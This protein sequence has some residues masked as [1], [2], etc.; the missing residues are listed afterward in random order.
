[1][2]VRKIFKKSVKMIPLCLINRISGGTSRMN[3][4]K[5]GGQF[6]VEL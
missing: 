1:M 2:K 3:C 6:H 4:R 5:G